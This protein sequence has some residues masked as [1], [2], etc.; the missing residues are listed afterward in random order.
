MLAAERLQQIHLFGRRR[1]RLIAQ[2]RRPAES[3]VIAGGVIGSVAQL[4]EFAVDNV[5]A[6][7]SHEFVGVA[8]R[9]DM[10]RE[11]PHSQD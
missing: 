4:V 10:V 1:N 6:L 7:G 9:R 5:I 11:I 2:T 8:H 3:V